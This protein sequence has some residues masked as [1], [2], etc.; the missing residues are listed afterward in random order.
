MVAHIVKHL[1]VEKQKKVLLANFDESLG[2]LTNLLKHIGC[3]P[4]M[5]VKSGSLT[6]INL[7]QEGLDWINVELPFVNNPTSV[8]KEGSATFEDKPQS[9]TAAG[10]IKEI[11]G[12][13]KKLL[14]KKVTL[15]PSKLSKPMS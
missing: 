4:D 3:Q 13:L 10:R 14:I 12:G 15:F 2:C 5:L 9:T 6:T 11:V 8:W 1:T 7:S